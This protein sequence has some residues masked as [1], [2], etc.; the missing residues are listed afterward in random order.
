MNKGKA[1][2]VRAASALR[3]HFPI[4]SESFHSTK[5]NFCNF[6]HKFLSIIYDSK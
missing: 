5:L 2:E 4:D 3:E 1:H 6:P